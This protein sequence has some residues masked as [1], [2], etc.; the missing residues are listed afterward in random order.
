[1]TSF[2]FLCDPAALKGAMLHTLLARVPQ[3][4]DVVHLLLTITTV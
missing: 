1:M 4:Q 3:S 2:L